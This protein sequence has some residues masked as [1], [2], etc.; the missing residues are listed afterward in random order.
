M[1]RPGVE[2]VNVQVWVSQSKWWAVRG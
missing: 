2:T 1:I